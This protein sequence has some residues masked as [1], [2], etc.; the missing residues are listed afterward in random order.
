MDKY[1][2]K[3]RV[4]IERD[5]DTGDPIPNGQTYLRCVKRNADGKVYRYNEHTLVCYMCGTGKI[6]NTIEKMDEMK[7]KYSVEWYSGEADIYFEE[8]DLDKLVELFG[9]TSFGADIVPTSIKNHPRKDEIRQERLD[10]MSEEE[11][12]RRRARGLELSRLLRE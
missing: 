11:K 6:N 9:L 3:Y 5:I 10:G 7:L 2:G 12:E 1:I 8:D 4:E